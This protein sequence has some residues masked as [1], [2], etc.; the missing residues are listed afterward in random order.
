VTAEYGI[1]RLI[2]PWST[3][4]DLPAGQPYPNAPTRPDHP[5]CYGSLDLAEYSAN[6]VY[7]PGTWR[8][9]VREVTD[10]EPA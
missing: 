6:Q 8:V 5:G 3:N 1:Q 4:P 7:D 2:P 10:W 9:L